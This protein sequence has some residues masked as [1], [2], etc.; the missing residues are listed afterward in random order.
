M[1]NIEAIIEGILFVIGDDGITLTQLANTLEVDEQFLEEKLDEM[2]QEYTN[3]DKIGI[4]MVNYGGRY[5]LVSKAICHDYCKKIYEQ[6]D[7]KAFSQAALETLAII[8]YK[9]PI[10]RVEIEE[11]RGVGCDMMLRKLIAR[12]LVKEGERLDV[13]GRPFT[14]LV[15]EKFM[16]TFKLKSLDELPELPNYQEES[17][18]ERELFD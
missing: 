18:S 11:I 9:Q 13:P 10:T 14:Y 12:G 8:A 1:D 17:E 6:A 7:S 5:K 3:N 15:T 16:D 2:S 4:E